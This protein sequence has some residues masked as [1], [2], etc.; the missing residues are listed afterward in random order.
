MPAAGVQRLISVFS[1][2]ALVT[3]INAASGCLTRGRDL[4]E[5]AIDL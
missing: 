4:F 1:V 5:V 2:L 3:T